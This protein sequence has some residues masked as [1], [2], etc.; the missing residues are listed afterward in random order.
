MGSRGYEK[1]LCFFHH[2]SFNIDTC[3]NFFS[4]KNPLS[5][6]RLLNGDSVF[7]HQFFQSVLLIIIFHLTKVLLY[8]CRFIF[9][10]RSKSNL[11]SIM[12]ITIMRI[13]QVQSI[14]K[15]MNSSI[16]LL[17]LEPE[18]FIRRKLSIHGFTLVLTSVM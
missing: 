13:N 11:L 15:K 1:V 18:Y 10:I 8:Q 9:P 3:Y 7:Q 6:K 16:I 17:P 4:T 2:S 12:V 14:M 5:R